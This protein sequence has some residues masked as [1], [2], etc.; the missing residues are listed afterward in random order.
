[1]TRLSEKFKCA[2][3]DTR[4]NVFQLA[5]PHYRQRLVE[6]LSGQARF[7]I[8]DRQATVGVRSAVYAEG[9]VSTGPNRFCINGRIGT[10]KIPWTTALLSPAAV[11]ELNPRLISTWVAL[12]LRRLM[13]QHTMAWGHVYP[14]RGA[15]SGSELL[16][17]LQRRL[18]SGMITYTDAE[19]SAFRRMHPGKKAFVAANS[20]YSLHDFARHDVH[21]S[22]VD[23]Q[24]FVAIG[25]LVADKGPVEALEAL[26]RTGLPHL[27]LDIVGDGPLRGHLET[28]IPELGLTDRVRLHGEVTDFDALAAIFDGAI[29]LVCPGYVGLN[30]TQSLGFGVPVIYRSDAYHAPE[31]TLLN[32]SNSTS[33]QGNDVALLTAALVKA[34]KEWQLSPTA[35]MQIAT[36]VREEYNIEAMAEGFR[37]ARA[38]M[39]STRSLWASQS[40]C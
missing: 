37:L 11:V 28:R 25:R 26:A 21:A 29:A 17:K 23:R 1:M 18:T 14:R 4:L 30:V 2:W 15:T 3:R 38:A 19:A 16:R 24:S 5:L 6:E 40:S 22:P 20:I 13:R 8:G 33:Y 32:S 9:I 7:F 39:A 34:S 35:R 31:V 12:A 36:V 27:K 10:Q